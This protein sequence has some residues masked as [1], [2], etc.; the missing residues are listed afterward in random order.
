MSTSPCLFG[1]SDLDPLTAVPGTLAAAAETE[2]LFL[3]AP[4]RELVNAPKPGKDFTSWLCR[5][6]EKSVNVGYD[7]YPQHST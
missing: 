1:G 4:A 6:R 7:L 2:S 5:E 3:L